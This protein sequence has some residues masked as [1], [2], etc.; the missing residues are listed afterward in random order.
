MNPQ[1]PST[2]D[3]GT[4]PASPSTTDVPQWSGPKPEQER[5]Y[6]TLCHLLALIYLVTFVPLTNI[7]GP[8]ILWALKKDEMPF[9]ED[10]G[11]ESLNFQLTVAA[12]E[13]LCV[14]LCLLFLP[15]KGAAIVLG[16]IRLFNVAFVIIASVKA[17]RGDV[18]RYPVCVRFIG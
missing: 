14:P 6:G 10:Q 13:I 1:S 3:D 9:V 12:A 8:L 4:A 2:H 16:A 11:R 17:Y 15:L 7:I 5:A 18:Y